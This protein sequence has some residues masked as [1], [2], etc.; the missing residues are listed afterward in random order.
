MKRINA[1]YLILI[2]SFLLMIIN[3][4]NLDFNDLS[5]NNYS[6]IVSNI[7]LIASMIFTIRDLKKIK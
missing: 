1:A 4:I 2:V 5:K 7:L 6:G 3:I